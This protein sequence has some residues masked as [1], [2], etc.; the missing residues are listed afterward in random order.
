[1]YCK[2]IEVYVRA[3]NSR[4]D[5]LSKEELQKRLEEDYELDISVSN[6]KVTATSGGS[7]AGDAIEGD[8]YAHTS[9]GNIALTNWPAAWKL[10]PAAG[11]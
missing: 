2:R 4:A 5:D 10:P 9:G 7:I 6:N 3:N 1:M 11:Q 8:L